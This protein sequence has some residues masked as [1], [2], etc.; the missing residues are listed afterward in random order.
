[1]TFTSGAR[2]TTLKER[3]L[4]NGLQMRDWAHFTDVSTK[5]AGDMDALES[6]GDKVK[7]I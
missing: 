5:V 4:K 6:R 1:M 7:L 3:Q 2:L